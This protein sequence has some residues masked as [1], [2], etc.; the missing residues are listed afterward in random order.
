MR[1]GIP[2]NYFLH[3]PFGRIK[4]MNGMNIT[5]RLYLP[6]KK[7]FTCKKQLLLELNVKKN[8]KKHF[9]E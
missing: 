1:M 4:I 2:F 3:F 9:L 8:K 7:L 5:G 6:M